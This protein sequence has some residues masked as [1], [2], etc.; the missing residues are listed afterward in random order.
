MMLLEFGSVVIAWR[1]RKQMSVALSTTKEEYIVS[2]SA[3]REVVW[4]RK[5]LLGLF[6]LEMDVTCIYCNNQSCIKLLENPVFHDKSKY[7]EIKY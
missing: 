5:M 2:C 1:S 7:I 4:L 3:S 6:E